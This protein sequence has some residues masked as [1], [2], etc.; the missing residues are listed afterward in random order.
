M[1]HVYTFYR[2]AVFYVKNQGH[3]HATR[4]FF[5][6]LLK[7]RSSLA[8]ILLGIF[9][10]VITLVSNL[11]AGT[12]HKTEVRVARASLTQG[13]IQGVTIQN[14]DIKL[15]PA[16][17]QQENQAPTPTPTIKLSKSYYTIAVIGDSMVDTMG[18]RMEYLEGALKKKYPETTFF[19]YNYGIGSENAEMGLDRFNKDFKYKDRNFPAISKIQADIIIVGSF[20]Y[21]PFSP[22]DR[23]KHW[24]TLTKLVQEALKKKDANVYMI[25]EAAPLRRNFGK[26][27]GGPNWDSNTSFT[28]SGHIIEQ[29]ENVIALG[30]NLNVPVIDVFH[31]SIGNESLKEG[32]REFVDTYDGIHPGV[33]GQEFMAEEIANALILK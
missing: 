23:D 22:H 25:A 29:L 15:P 12:L 10:I 16:P 33:K 6:H 4:S 8:L 7:K 17:S 18:E 30:R 20:A 28:H 11:I 19:L 21:N 14:S 24:L 5:Q 32:K 9:F 1:L 31:K 13:D 2:M 3:H 26:G 27:P